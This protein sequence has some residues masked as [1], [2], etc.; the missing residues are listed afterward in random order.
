MV[1]RKTEI[2]ESLWG[3]KR[4]HDLTIVCSHFIYLFLVRAGEKWPFKAPVN[5]LM[6][7]TGIA[8]SMSLRIAITASH[9]KELM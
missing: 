2:S 5:F 9:L 3:K 4:Q 1:L 8:S 7:G 6:Q